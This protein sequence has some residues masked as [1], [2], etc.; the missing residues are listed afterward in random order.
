[1][2]NK[3]FYIETFGCQMNKNDSELMAL[4]MTGEGFLPA[5]AVE[6]ADIIIFNTCSVREH[7][8]NRALARMRGSR[9]QR[10]SRGAIVVA[11]GCMAQRIG[12]DLLAGGTAD[13]VV[14]PY[15]VPAL[16]RLV[17]SYL[18]DPGDN[19]YLSQETGD[20]AGRINPKL[21]RTEDSPGWHRW[22]TI[23]HGC[24]NYCSYCIVPMVRGRLISFPS[25][26]ILEYIRGLAASGIKEITLLGQNVNQYGTDS[27][28]IP[29]YRLLEAAAAISGIE[30]I[31]FLT[32]HPRDFS[33]SILD[34]I[35]DHSNIS[36]SIHLP[37]QSGS[38]RILSLMNRKYTRADYLKIV[39]KIS[40]RLG[41]YSLSTD[42]I[43][44]FPGET[45][46]EF[47]D[48]LSAVESIRFDD[49]Y[50]YAYSPRSGTPAYS[51]METLSR[52]EKIE[53]LQRLIGLQRS[54]SLQRL[55]ERISS[56][57]DSIIER[58]SKKSTDRVMGRSYL[59]HVVITDGTSED[60]GKRLQIRIHSVR[61]T[62]LHGTRIA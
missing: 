25:A 5:S 34:V 9:K 56:I 37:L 40:A 21:C 10:R 33:D 3:T 35:S 47:M 19:T 53:R 48:T 43:V 23:T 49:A 8:E 55:T 12:G 16:G 22:V 51:S 31:N 42:L 7:A 44:G 6:K 60:F 36:R 61:G 14:G 26:Q 50:N 15:Q 27:N 30:R 41:T 38:D 29:F 62:T 4:S 45:E 2:A 54:V 24:E 59:N 11:A 46:K 28:D 17:R 52:E 32:S 18:A 1:M 39:E 20:F 13:M 57:E 58:Y